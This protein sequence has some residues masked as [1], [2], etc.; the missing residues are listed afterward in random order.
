MP[1]DVINRVNK[2]RRD[3]QMTSTITYANRKGDKIVDT[4]HDYDNNKDVNNSTHG[5][6][7]LEEDESLHF[8]DPNKS[9]DD[10]ASMTSSE[11]DHSLPPD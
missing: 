10:S 8:D 11:S 2:I 4:I 1:T 9:D 7:S 5:S 6:V 3:Q